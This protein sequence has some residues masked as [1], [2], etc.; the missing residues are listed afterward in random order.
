MRFWNRLHS[1]A[2]LALLAVSA[3]IAEAREF[4]DEKGRLLKLPPLIE[5]TLAAYDTH[6]GALPPIAE[7]LPLAPRVVDPTKSGRQFGVHG[8]SWRMFIEKAKRVRLGVVYGYAR[9][10]CYDAD[11]A[12]R[13]DLLLSFDVFE[14][15]KFVFK[16]RPGHKWS[17]GAPFTSEDFRYWWEDVANHPKLSPGGPPRFMLVNGE[18]PR[19][20]FPDSTTVIYE[21]SSPNPYFL[22]KL[23]AAAPPFIYRPAHYM[24][25]FH[26]KYTDVKKLEAKAKK[27]G[28][29]GW[30]ALHNDSD[31][32]YK[33]DNPDLPTL[34]P[35]RLAKDLSGRR[36]ILIRNAFFHR[37]DARGRQ[38]P[39]ID[40]LEMI[41]AS[42]SL[43]AAK[44]ASGEADLQARN[45]TFPDMA[46]LKSEEKRGGFEARLWRKGDA[47]QMAL[48]P[49]LN[50]ADPVWRKVLRDA[51]F[52]RA[53]SMAIDR[54]LINRVLYFD[55]AKPVGNGPLPESPLYDPGFVKPWTQFDLKAA[56][57]LLD[58]MGLKRKSARGYRFLPDGRPLEVIV[59]YA[60][61]PAEAADALELMVETW[62]EIGVRLL[63]RPRDRDSLRKGVES[64]SVMIAVWTGWSNG[65]PTP[66]DPPL[67]LAPMQQS[68]FQWPKWGQ[69]FETKG[70][71][72]EAPDTPEG[73]KL[74][75]LGAAWAKATTDDAR[76]AIWRKMLAIHAEQL[77]VIGVAS[78]APQ[79]VVVS[80][81]MRNVPKSGVWAWDPGAR[82]GV[83]RPDLFFFAP[84]KSA[85]KKS[86]EK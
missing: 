9:L 72:G 6:A 85:D 35:W 50:Y 58:E 26:A 41:V 30:A 39:Y 14:G 54:R 44:S 77:F 4:I 81:A 53:L 20:T 64:G 24:K 68:S 82:F 76:A 59:E 33:N 62:R 32:M 12:L 3:P 78:G 22:K 75:A 36:F 31:N 86:G 42:S 61:D 8:G 17:D 74:M 40:R 10:I 34:Q 7:R 37:I 51:R 79:P 1:A 16:L 11:Y 47:S 46:V 67:D 60:S 83:Y 28:L 45:I 13:P 19:V 48:Y 66:S 80:K 49:N 70:K 43:T 55:L 57:A 69:F 73:R 52:R 25:K 15:R 5:H 84:S 71:S 56:N 38:L 63:T 29:R 21:W 23:A 27:A 2:L 65:L 18:P